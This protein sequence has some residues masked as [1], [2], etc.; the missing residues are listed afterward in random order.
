MLWKKLHSDYFVYSLIVIGSLSVVVGA[1]VAPHPD[2]NVVQMWL[3]SYPKQ[4]GAD[5]T[6]SFVL[7]V[8]NKG[9]ETR[10]YDLEVLLDGFMKQ[11]ESINLVP[12]E[13]QQKRFSVDRI[14]VGKHQAKVVVFDPR[15]PASDFGSQQKPYSV[16]FWFDA[17]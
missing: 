10:N 2:D 1:L 6:F 16:S 14:S 4:V 11:Q 5:D 12:G 9:T 3:E 15:S 13:H 8:E 17:A 7:I